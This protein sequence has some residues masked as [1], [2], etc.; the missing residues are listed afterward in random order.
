M[1]YVGKILGIYP[2]PPPSSAF[3]VLFKDQLDQ[4]QLHRTNSKRLRVLVLLEL[5]LT[6]P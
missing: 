4:V 3:S 1:K 5:D 6:D 2:P